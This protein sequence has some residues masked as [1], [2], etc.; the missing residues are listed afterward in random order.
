MARWTEV[1]FINLTGM[2][3]SDVVSLTVL[4]LRRK[5]PP[6]RWIILLRR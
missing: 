3:Q 2:A 4:F 5:D 1:A 6:R